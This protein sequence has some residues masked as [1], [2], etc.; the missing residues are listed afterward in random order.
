MSTGFYNKV[1]VFRQKKP[2]LERR[3]PGGKE[4]RF[5]RTYATIIHE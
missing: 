1:K 4:D 2:P 3:K 5:L